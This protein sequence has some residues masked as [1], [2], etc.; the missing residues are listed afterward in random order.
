MENYTEK[1]VDQF[2]TIRY[3]NAIKQWHRTDGPAVEY[4]NGNKSW[5][6]NGKSHHLDGPAAIWTNENKYKNKVWYIKNKG[7]EKSQHN[8]LVLFFVLEPRRINLNPT[9]DE[10]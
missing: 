5:Y 3:Y 1:E 10:D 2:G 6:I 8:R 9:E 4:I 7:Y